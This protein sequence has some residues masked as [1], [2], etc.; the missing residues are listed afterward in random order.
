MPFN[1]SQ[2]GTTLSLHVAR[3][4]FFTI[5]FVSIHDPGLTKRLY[6]KINTSS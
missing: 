2:N 6:L 4:R 1:F 3:I 5:T